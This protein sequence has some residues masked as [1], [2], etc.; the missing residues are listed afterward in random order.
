LELGADA[1]PRVVS[2]GIAPDYAAQVVTELAKA[3][4][5]VQ[6]RL[7]VAQD[8]QRREYNSRHRELQ[9][10]IGDQVLVYKPFRRVKRAEK[11][12]HRWQGPFTVIRQTTPVNYEV[13]A[14]YFS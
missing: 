10:Q 8:N 4:A 5:V 7:S 14:A 1:N 3:R 6:T 9:F 13:A 11:L 12:L 2:P